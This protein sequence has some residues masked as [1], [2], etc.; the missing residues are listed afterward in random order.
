MRITGT[1]FASSTNTTAG[2]SLAGLADGLQ[3]SNNVLGSFWQSNVVAKDANPFCAIRFAAQSKFKMVCVFLES[4]GANINIGTFSGTNPTSIAGFTSVRSIAFG[5]T[6][7]NGEPVELNKMLTFYVFETEADGVGIWSSGGEQP[8]FLKVWEIYVGDGIPDNKFLT[9]YGW[10]AQTW[11]AA[12]Y[13][14]TLDI[15]YA[16]IP[17]AEFVLLGE[18]AHLAGYRANCTNCTPSTYYYSYRNRFSQRFL[19][20]KA[21]THTRLRFA[22]SPY[23]LSRYAHNDQTSINNAMANSVTYTVHANNL[24]LISEATYT[25]RS[26]LQLISTIKTQ[27]VSTILQLAR[28]PSN[29]EPADATIGWTG[30]PR[31]SATIT[32]FTKDDVAGTTIV[33]TQTVR[34]TLNK[35][36]NNGVDGSVTPIQ[37]TQTPQALLVKDNKNGYTVTPV[38]TTQ[39]PQAIL[40]KDLDIPNVRVATLYAQIAYSYDNIPIRTTAIPQALLLEDST[41]TPIRV[42]QSAQ[43]LLVKQGPTDRRFTQ[44]V[45]ALLVKE[46]PTEFFLNFRPLILP[47]MKTLYTSSKARAF[48]VGDTDYIQLEG[49]LPEGSHLL[50]NGVNVGRT[51]PVANGDTFEVVSGVMN[52]FTTSILIYRYEWTGDQTIRELVGVWPVT[53]PE[54]SPIW[55]ASQERDAVQGQWVADFVNHAE[56]EFELAEITQPKVFEIQLTPDIH[57][58]KFVIGSLEADIHQYKFATHRMN[59]DVIKPKTFTHAITALSNK[60]NFAEGSVSYFAGFDQIDKANVYAY[61]GSGEIHTTDAKS[62]VSNTTRSKFVAQEFEDSFGNMHSILNTGYVYAG[63]TYAIASTE[64]EDSFAQIASSGMS[65]ESRAQEILL[66]DMNYVDNSTVVHKIVAMS[67]ASA[68]D[69]AYTVDNKSY[70]SSND[71]VTYVEINFVAHMQAISKVLQ[72][73][74]VVAERSR[75]VDQYFVRYQY[76]PQDAEQ[77]VIPVSYKIEVGS[78]VYVDK[79]YYVR[80]NQNTKVIDLVPVANSQN[81]QSV[82]FDYE[83]FGADSSFVQ[84]WYAKSEYRPSLVQQVY[85]FYKPTLIIVESPKAMV[86][87]YPETFYYSAGRYAGFDTIQELQDF[88]E[89]FEG[90]K[91]IPAY[92]GYRYTTEVDET[93]VCELVSNGP[94]KWLL[95]GG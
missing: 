80:D 67:Y 22:L 44:V 29:G 25:E 51:T 53:Q 50:R 32:V 4:W 26:S 70:V 43:G 27:A 52:Y 77:G 38:Q 2:A 8:D 14:A 45:S 75:F 36:I 64:Y 37:T 84:A 24:A 81:S 65:Y 6:D 48:M 13:N 73:Y 57:Q 7:D 39:T 49:Y 15:H 90:T 74:D 82:S 56:N 34:A 12:S 35:N 11:T 66:A 40:T 79:K 55:R 54:L 88:T 94:V 17:G 85:E 19:H 20:F 63:A 76:F 92:G 89:Y 3:Y 23:T 69:S 21:V 42:T 5:D 83:K 93:F 72:E 60:S 95:Q 58:Y 68:G 33:G 47:D 71:S 10:S 87:T 78:A 91:A 46:D 86:Y 18:G 16:A 28:S 30:P 41:I 62:Y 1:P 61:K 31:S 59:A 9:Y